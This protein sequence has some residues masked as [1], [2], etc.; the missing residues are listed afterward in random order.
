MGLKY[1]LSKYLIVI[2]SIKYLS[3]ESC[4]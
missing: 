3:A 1:S 2:Y 4:Q